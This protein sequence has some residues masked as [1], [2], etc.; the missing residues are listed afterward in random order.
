MTE[1]QAMYG[2]QTQ[3][4]VKCIHDNC[5]QSPDIIL[6]LRCSSEIIKFRAIKPIISL[7]G[8]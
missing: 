8:I 5:I 7:Y 1:E 4:S 6:F 3:L 2:I